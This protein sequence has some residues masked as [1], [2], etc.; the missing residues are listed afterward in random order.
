MSTRWCFTI[1][2]PP[3]GYM[4]SFDAERVAYMI[5]QKERGDETGTLHIQGYIR[6]FTRTRLTSVQH[7]LDCGKPHCEVARGTEQQ[8]GPDYCAKSA[9][10]V[11]GPWE[12]G[13]ID[14]EAGTKGRRC[15]LA[16][17]CEIIKEGGTDH[18][19]A[20]M[21]PTTFVKY[22]KGLGE[23]RRAIRDPP[24]VSR[25][26]DV[27]VLWGTTGTGKSHRVRTQYPDAYVVVPGKGPF[28]QYDDQDVVIFEEFCW[29]DWTVTDM[30]RYLDK[31]KCPLA[32]RYTN[33]F[34]SWTKVFILSNTNP[35]DWYGNI[36]AALQDAFQRRL[37]HIDQVYSI[38]QEIKLI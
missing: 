26:V 38:S 11:E 35:F 12:F 23:Y 31:W 10:R 18:E 8:A 7:Y 5:F 9:T 27:Q 4:P 17:A 15:D 21:C 25:T 6:F 14:P 13:Y 22:H 32:C 16:S 1:N 37:T 29:T 33:K 36:P 24:A 28:D 30:N 34:A 3:D 20:E 2:N 19:V